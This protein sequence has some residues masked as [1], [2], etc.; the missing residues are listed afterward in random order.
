[1]YLLGLIRSNDR[2]DRERNHNRQVIRNRL[3]GA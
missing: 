1:M 3:S 2:R